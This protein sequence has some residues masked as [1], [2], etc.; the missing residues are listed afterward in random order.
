MFFII[1][2]ELGIIFSKLVLLIFTVYLY[3]IFQII[4]TN[5]FFQTLVKKKQKKFL[6][7]ILK[8]QKKIRKKEIKSKKNKSKRNKKNN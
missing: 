4:L 1:F 7:L 6:K 5:N 8:L 2:I 3:K